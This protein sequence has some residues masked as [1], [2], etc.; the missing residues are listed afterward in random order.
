LQPWGA[1]TAHDLA[2]HE[3]VLDHVVNKGSKFFWGTQP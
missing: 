3:T 2:V 1:V